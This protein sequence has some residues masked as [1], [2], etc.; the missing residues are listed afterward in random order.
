VCFAISLAVSAGLLCVL[1]NHESW[2]LVHI[3]GA[4]AQVA[5]VIL[6]VFGI[7]VSVS[8]GVISSDAFFIQVVPACTGMY[9]MAIYLSAVIAIH[10]SWKEKVMGVALGVLG[11][12]CLNVLRLVS[13]FAIGLYFPNVLEQAH[14][15]VWQSLVIFATVVLWL[16]WARKIG[17]EP[18]AT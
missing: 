8:G 15:L 7:D 1:M 18:A 9:P 14:L 12:F 11:L 6:R 5:A 3:E 13:L 16:S 10:C 4:L 2:F 17:H